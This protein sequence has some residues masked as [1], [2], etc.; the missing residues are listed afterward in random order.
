MHQDYTNLAYEDLDSAF[1]EQN[2]RWAV[3]KAY[4]SLFLMCN[5]ILVKK[6]G[7]YSKDHNCLII[8]LS[9][10]NLIPEEILLRIHNLLKDKEKLFEG[11]NPHDSFF[12]EISKI[13]IERNNYLY[14]PNTLRKINKK[15]EEILN[16]VRE[17]IKILG[18][19]E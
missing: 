9:N 1:K 19:I 3:T 16:Q 7:F 11:F 5:S 12:E 17:L 13:R 18:E 15:S 2:V 14:L 6:R 4:Q 10:E 8:A